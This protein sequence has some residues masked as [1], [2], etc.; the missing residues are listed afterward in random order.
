[1]AT[2]SAAT[3]AE[4]V[5]AVQQKLDRANIDKLVGHPT[6]TALENLKQQT[7]TKQFYYS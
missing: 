7:G 3:E 2:V 5:T 4:I 1:M 6:I